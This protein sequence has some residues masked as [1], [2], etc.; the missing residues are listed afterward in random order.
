M[1]ILIE[2][3]I[4][5]CQPST[6]QKVTCVIINPCVAIYVVVHEVLCV[7]R[8]LCVLLSMCILECQRTSCGAN[9]VVH[10]V[11][12]QLKVLASHSIQPVSLLRSFVFVCLCKSARE[13]KK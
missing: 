4:L 8:F 11:D 10:L 5:L 1:Q 7:C 3:M 13:R 12:P 6:S 9:L 2:L